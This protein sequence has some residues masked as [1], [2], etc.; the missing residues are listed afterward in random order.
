MPKFEDLTGRTFN[1]LHV[2]RVHGRDKHGK[3]LYE[4]TCEC[5][6]KTITLGRSLKN[7]HTKSCGCILQKYH[8]ENSKYK[9]LH[10]T[11]I[12]NIWKGMNDRC[13][14]PNNQNY[15]DY[16]GRGIK[17]CEEW[18]GDK[19]FYNFLEWA[20]E[21]GYLKTLT[22]DRINNDGKYE[23]SNCRWSDYATQAN[24]RRKPPRVKNQYGT[25]NYRQPLPDPYKELAAD[26]NVV[27]K[28][29]KD[30][31]A[32]TFGDKIRESNGS[33]AYMLGRLCSRGATD[34]KTFEMR[35]WTT[36]KWLDYLNQPYTE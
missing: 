22:I 8:F 32:I 34:I 28:S 26:N 14:N 13:N 27:T 29:S 17:V 2:D 3:I 21:S 33:L 9:G 12:Y 5:G 31:N 20:L 30:N 6:N 24:N 11:R 7:N 16:G 25:W 10:N 23:P 15:K 1:M 35:G 18:Q 4:C 36:K 19:G